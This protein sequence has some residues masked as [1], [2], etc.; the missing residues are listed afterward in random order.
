[1]TMLSAIAIVFW[2]VAKSVLIPLAKPSF[3]KWAKFDGI[4]YQLGDILC[5]EN[6]QEPKFGQI[7]ALIGDESNLIFYLERFQ[8][9]SY[10][11]YMRAYNLKSIENS[12]HIGINLKD[13]SNKFPIDLYELD[14]LFYIS[15]KYPL[16]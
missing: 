7:S 10:V 9:I 14:N 4:K 3:V 13:L 8:T 2:L 12:M 15:L 1:M 16:I 6:N 5:Y 11:S